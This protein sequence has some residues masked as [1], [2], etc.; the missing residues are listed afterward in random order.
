M[1]SIMQ[2]IGGYIK[3]L[4]LGF[5]K[6]SLTKRATIAVLLIVIL[7][8]PAF[9]GNTE[10]D[11]PEARNT[12]RTVSVQSVG[13][14]SLDLT[15][16]SLFGTVISKSEATIRA[17][18]GG[19]IVGVYKKLGDYAAAGTV[20]AEFE[21]SAE[22]AQ[23]LSAEG[24]YESAS[25]GKDI[26]SISLGSS[27]NVVNEAKTQAINILSSTYTGLDDAIR[28]KTDP[29]WRN[30]QTREAHL[31]V[32]VS[33]AK[34][35]IELEAERINIE[36]MLR[37]REAKNKTIS[38]DSDLVAELTQ[39]EADANTVKDYLDD[40]SLAF[41]RALADG[42]ASQSAIDG[43]KASTAGAR[44]SVGGLLSAI[45]NSR[46]A[47]NSSL[48]A[49]LIAEKNSSQPEGGSG[50]ATDAQVKSALG[51]LR[52]AQSR[53]EKTIIRSPISGT[54]NSLSISTGDFISP[55][56]EVAVV[57]NNGALE[58][59]AYVT[60]EDARELLALGKV[61]IEGG[62]KGVITRVAPA[63]DPKTK[64]IEVRIGIVGGGAT[65][66]NGQSVQIEL[67]RMQKK[68]T[69]KEIKIPLS[70]LKITPTRIIVFTVSTEGTLVAHTVK[71]G[72][73][74]GD[75]VVIMEGLT[76]DMEI[77]TDA[78]GLQEGMA[79]SLTK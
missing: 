18:S 53:L 20:I 66:I 32:T 29:A 40:L 16:L 26:A 70:A 73:L 13:A 15:T 22:R 24:A 52:G 5:W 11:V 6:L 58:V 54:I 39:I 21:N 7:S 35:I 69:S 71:Q 42:N 4:A 36:T 28:T 68:S 17:E 48:S 12:T 78:R 56:T 49:N 59:L 37:A 14:L 60:E 64:K 51:N 61:D 62:S 74:L 72:A 46:N 47:L 1:K 41:N 63:L 76:V 67:A 57:S 50:G 44:G 30:P 79:V 31:A 19:K 38:V 23:V 9:I 33:D 34:L 8:I 45:T 2:F 10:S 55:F 3:A 75:Q 65:L 25:F 77:V 43:Y 27:D